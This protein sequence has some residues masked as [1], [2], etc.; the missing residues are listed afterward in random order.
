MVQ[1]PHTRARIAAAGAIMLI[2]AAL[3]CLSVGAFSSAAPSHHDDW[4]RTANGWERTASGPKTAA[5]PAKNNASQP[6][7]YREFHGRFDTHP[8][9]LALLQLVGALGALAAFRS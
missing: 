8:A 4:R 3:S 9:A 5:L 2:G 1:S 6:A 7:T